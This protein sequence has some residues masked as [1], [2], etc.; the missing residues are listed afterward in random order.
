V[1]PQDAFGAIGATV[2]I[3]AV[4]GDP[5]RGVFSRLLSGAAR[6][7]RARPGGAERQRL[8]EDL[9]ILQEEM[10][11][12]RS[13]IALLRGR[14]GNGRRE[15]FTL[16]ELLRLGDRREVEAVIRAHC[17]TLTLP[18]GTLLCRV[19]ARHKLLVDGADA[20]LAPHL[21]L[22]GYWEYWIT[23]F[24]CRNL[25]RGE[26]ALD[27]GA[28]YGYYSAI[29]AD[30]VGPEGRVHAFEATPRAHALLARNLVLNALSQ[31]S[32]H[33]AAAA[34]CGDGAPRLLRVPLADPQSA[35]L[36]PGATAEPTT[37][38]EAEGARLHAVPAVALDA[39]AGERVDLVKIDAPGSEE[40]IWRGMQ[41]LLDRNPRLR[42]LMDFAP[43]RI[44]DAAALLAEFG[45][46]FPLRVVESDGRARPC[47]AEELLARA[48]LPRM[49]YLSQAEPR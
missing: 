9:S 4:R 23:E 5:R 1:S 22:D 28:S 35:H 49:L 17:Q 40:A 11:H 21:M 19:L 41:A 47:T 31:V 32:A 13:E 20:G 12:L 37:T 43:Q 42:V 24:V 36:L 10:F 45:G 27:V 6:L 46:R 15:V 7:L 33:P 26:T 39:F 14:L 16:A 44:G 2:P 18:D 30:L 38:A 25:D 8:R 48:A 29:F 3:R 34:E